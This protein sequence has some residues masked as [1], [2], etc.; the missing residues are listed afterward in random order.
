[1]IRATVSLVQGPESVL[2]AGEN[3]THVRLHMTSTT[4]GAKL[5]VDDVSLV[6]VGPEG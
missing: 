4:T 1:M 2:P 6:E 5:Y 3:I